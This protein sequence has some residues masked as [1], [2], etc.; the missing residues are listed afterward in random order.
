MKILNESGGSNNKPTDL[1]SNEQA[2]NVMY[3]TGRTY[4]FGNYG[5]EKNIEMAFMFL[6]LAADTNEHLESMFLLYQLLSN[7]MKLEKDGFEYC[8]KA[9]EKGH[10]K[11]QLQ[12]VELYAYGHGCERDEEKARQMGKQ[13]ILSNKDKSTLKNKKYDFEEIIKLGRLVCAF[14]DSNGL[15]KNG[16]TLDSR[17]SRFVAK[18]NHLLTDNETNQMI[19]NSP[20]NKDGM[21][22]ANRLDLIF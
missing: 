1:L 14:E 7:E 2:V 21:L 16:V 19:N 22:I 15:S 17:L 4:M 9:A 11:A 8:L 6:K 20:G 12:L 10:H 5:K 13:A 3:E 18:T